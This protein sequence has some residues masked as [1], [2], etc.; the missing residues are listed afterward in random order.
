MAN[1][2]TNLAPILRNGGFGTISKDAQQKLI[3]WDNKLNGTIDTLGQI[4]A[5]ITKLS[6]NTTIDGRAGTIGTALSNLDQT[7]IFSSLGKIADAST[8]HLTDGT[9]TPLAGGKR[10]AVALDTNNRLI[11]SFRQNPV[12][13]SSSPNAS[14]GLS[15]DGVSTTI[16][17]AADSYRY[18]PGNVAYNSGSVDP[19]FF[20]GP[21]Y[22]FFDDPTFSGGAVTFRFSSSPVDTVGALGRIP[23]GS[24]T[25][26][27]AT[28]KTGGG[29]TGG[30]G[31]KPG[32]RGNSGA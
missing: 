15:N 31:G 16:V 10:G 4:Q 2:L 23:C 7:G 11:D 13:V 14:A 30:T 29:F 24:I 19:G 5:V 20:G 6:Q 12:D 26:V 9:G 22:V 27:S 1:Q 17:I 18:G 28:A 21:Y 3:E 32:G 25:T 8:D